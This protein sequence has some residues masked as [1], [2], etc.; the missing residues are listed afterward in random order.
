M[1]REQE[2]KKD[3]PDKVSTLELK[4]MSSNQEKK[5]VK[6][7]KENRILSQK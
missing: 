1:E 7:E 6:I 2:K 5:G 4:E 3:K